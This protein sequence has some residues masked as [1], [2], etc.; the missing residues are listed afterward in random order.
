[1]FRNFFNFVVK[2]NVGN[3]LRFSE[4]HVVVPK[5]SYT[6]FKKFMQKTV[7]VVRLFDQTFYDA[8]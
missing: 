3:L 6:F 1:M 7:E 4:H 8:P 5:L 2:L